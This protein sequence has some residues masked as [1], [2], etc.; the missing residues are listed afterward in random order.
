MTIE[1]WN[2]AIFDADEQFKNENYSFFFNNC[3]HYVT[4]VLNNANYAGHN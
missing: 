2:K 3:Y 1:K 4:T